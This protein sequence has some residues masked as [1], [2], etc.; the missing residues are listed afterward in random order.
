MTAAILRVG[1]PHPGTRRLPGSATTR[2]YPTIWQSI[3]C[4]PWGEQDLGGV[5]VLP[6]ER[7]VATLLALPPLLTDQQITQL[8]QRASARLQPAA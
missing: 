2:I 5:A 3:N 8:A 6:A 7:L 1:P 4:L